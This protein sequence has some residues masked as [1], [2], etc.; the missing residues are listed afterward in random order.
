[1]LAG[2]LEEASAFGAVDSSEGN[3]AARMREFTPVITWDRLE[4]G[5]NMNERE[6]T[7]T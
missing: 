5:P 2:R 6:F 3:T 4:I 1:M 7:K